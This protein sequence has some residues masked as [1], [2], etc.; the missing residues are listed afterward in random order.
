M[1]R[2]SL[3]SDV[4]ERQ[5]RE[6]DAAL[7][8]H[9]QKKKPVSPKETIEK[10]RFGAPLAQKE[11]TRDLVRVLFISRDESLLNQTS[12][13]LDGYLQLDQVF[14]EVHI[15]ILR[16]GIK[17]KYPVLR[18]S[19][20][21]WL[22]TATD[23]TWWQVPFRGIEM[24]IDQLSF[25]DG[26]R[27]DLIV[28]HDPFECGYVAQYLSKK[29]SR[30]FQIH[31]TENYL[32]STFRIKDEHSVWRRL[33]ASYVLRRALSVRTVSDQLSAII[34]KKFPM[35]ENIATLPRLNNIFQYRSRPVVVNIKTKYPDYNFHIMYFCVGSDFATIG[36]VLTRTVT[37]FANP[38]VG[39]V[40]MCAK[41]HVRDI[42]R[43]VSVL[44]IA[45][46]VVV[47]SS[48][49]HSIDF[50]KT[51]DVFMTSDVT[52][53]SDELVTIAASV[54]TPLVVA[55]DTQRSD[56]FEYGTSALLVPADTPG[57]LINCLHLLLNDSQ[58]RQ[59]LAVAALQVV[60]TRLHQDPQQYRRE[61]QRS[62]EEALFIAKRSHSDQDVT[63]EQESADSSSS[64]V[65][66]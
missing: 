6:L 27:P 26:F 64:T 20:T 34:G 47:L 54:E 11:S 1:S 32:A 61:Y 45:R 18:L 63:N 35:I 59:Q 57:E 66:T 44:G 56:L 51:A 10:A 7:Q 37:I 4:S 23:A 33:I 50:I 65:S 22:Y 31:I 46:H 40:I 60:A 12:Q 53:L 29:F 24:V 36:S 19:P 55:E 58:Y 15:L 17:A 30:P 43:K 28:A 38:R 62:I 5:R 16:T 48:T 2:S 8:Q 25:A 52:A 21:V 42:E 13:S 9:A 39:L 3:P 49:E 14:D 41:N